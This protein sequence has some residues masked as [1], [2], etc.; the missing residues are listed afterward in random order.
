MIDIRQSAVKL[1]NGL[2]DGDR[3]NLSRNLDAGYECYRGYVPL[4]YQQQFEGELKKL[5]ND[6]YCKGGC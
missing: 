6:Y 5:L 2:T 1:L 4:V 3:E